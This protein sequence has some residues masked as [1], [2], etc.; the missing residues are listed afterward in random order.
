M[1][2]DHSLHANT[3][4]RYLV[5]NILG[6]LPWA[7]PIRRRPIADEQVNKNRNDVE[8]QSLN[9]YER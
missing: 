1:F 7:R 6:I 9:V 5:A 3:I 8:N 2:E 4:L